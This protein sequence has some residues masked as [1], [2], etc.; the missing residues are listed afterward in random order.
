MLFKRIR[1]YVC[2]RCSPGRIGNTIDTCTSPSE[3][4]TSI[5][6]RDSDNI[7]TDNVSQ[8]ALEEVLG[9]FKVQPSPQIQGDVE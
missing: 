5:P 6:A 3:P 7:R 4:C 1:E 9:E 2:Y 8:E